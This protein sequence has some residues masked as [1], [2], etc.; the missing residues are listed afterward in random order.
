MPANTWTLGTLY[1]PQGPPPTT[2]FTQPG[3]P[4]TQVFPTQKNNQPWPEYPIPGL[5]IN[6]Y[7]PWWTPG[8]LHSVNYWL[9]IREFDVYSEQSVAL[10]C[11]PVCSY[12]QR[13]I[14]PYDAWLLPIENAIIAA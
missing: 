4:F 12:I 14:M 13:V 11:C 8:C 2:Y 1:Y 6:E 5:I 10:I 3:G 9:V 7:V